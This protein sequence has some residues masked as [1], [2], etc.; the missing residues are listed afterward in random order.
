MKNSP[1]FVLAKKRHIF[2]LTLTVSAF[3]IAG[4]YFFYSFEKQRIHED[5][6]NELKEIARLKISQIS[7]WNI[8]RVSDSKFVSGNPL[9]VKEIE[10]FFKDKNNILL[11]REITRTFSLMKEVNFYES[12]FIT[13]PSGETLL[14]TEG[15]FDKIDS[16]TLFFIKKASAEKTHLQTDLYVNSFNNE[17]YLDY[18]AP[19]INKANKVIAVV[20]LRVNP[21]EYL[22]PLIQEWPS[23]SRTSETLIVRKEDDNVLFLN[24][25][26]NRKNTALSFKVPLSRKNIP[27]VLAV[28][29]YTGIVEGKNYN[30]VNVL[31][32]IEP[33]KG[34]NWFMIAEVSENEIYSGLYTR[35]AFIILVTLLMILLTGTGL[36]F[37]YSFRQRNIY[38]ELFVKEK[39]LKEY[40]EEFRTV[41]YSIGDGVITTD[42]SGCIKQMNHTAEDLT[43]WSEQDACGI[44]LEQVFKI[45][46]EETRKVVENPVHKVLT[47]GTIV[48]LANHTLL[49]TKDG[50]EIPI[51]DSGSPIRDE[52]EKINGVVLVFRDKTEEHHAE[53]MIRQSEARLK[54]AEL[55][56]KSGNWEVHL[57]SGMA[58]YSDGACKIY[59]IHENNISVSEIQKYPLE[60]YRTYLGCA[61]WDLIETGKRYDVEYKIRNAD[62][63]EIH[64]IHSIAEYKKDKNCVFGVLTDITDLKRA[65]K[66]IRLLAH[67]VENVKECVSI[68]DEKN[69]LIFVNNA[70]V[71][72]YGYTKDELIGMNAGSLQPADDK[73]ENYQE[74]LI[75]TINGGWKGEIINQKKNGAKFPVQLSTSLIKNESGDPV[76]L[77]GVATDITEAKRSRDEL[78]LAKERAEEMNKLK[79][80]FLSNMSHE[81]RTPMIGIL[82]FSELLR[83]ELENSE[84]KKMADS[85]YSG[86]RR[87]LNTLNL[88]LDL[89]RIESNKEVVKM[90]RVNLHQQL[91]EILRTFKAAASNK[92]LFLDYEISDKNIHSILDKRIFDQVMNNLVNNAIKF[93][94]EGGIT[95]KA[96]LE[97]ND[98]KNWCLIKVIDTG[99]G[100]SE[101]DLNIIFEEFRQASEGLGRSFEGTGLGLTITKRSVELMNGTIN[102]DSL[103]G[104]GT[105]FSIRFPAVKPEIEFN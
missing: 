66:E 46:N 103:P 4:A 42:E 32:Y 84:L 6:H 13:S 94:L 2:F 31:S 7:K 36:A 17:I 24:D 51:A 91:S 40:H 62:T 30:G 25:I 55:I 27:A 37:V 101:A 44:P 83:T 35:E 9:I 48:G 93:T 79:T 58:V 105:T 8:E 59:G 75:E 98:G 85:I 77:I 50:R 96:E 89:A 52:Q 64:D 100:I 56:S 15:D 81:L 65:E 71:E 78:I 43:G 95:V 29:G 5:K 87:L 47:S 67:A 3:L 14:K 104:H 86:G 10:A 60:E 11:N 45:I 22:Y 80:N 21:N 70:F 41:L 1:R 82:G 76:A 20:V 63:G 73:K 33:V 23:P 19:V 28:F 90:E 57:D 54:R 39:E 72:T 68:T 38:K 26:R 12:I 53:K 61:M 49:I 16:T 18:I 102:V 97:N 69:N 74:V 99:I 92:N 34:T 88:V